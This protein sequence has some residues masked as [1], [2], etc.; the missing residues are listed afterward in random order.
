MNASGSASSGTPGAGGTRDYRKKH[1][2]LF[3]ED[4]Q[5][6]F[7]RVVP[8]EGK[9]RFTKLISLAAIHQTNLAR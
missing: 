7:E 6:I 4:P 5:P 1:R 2:V 8:P 3:R 9:R